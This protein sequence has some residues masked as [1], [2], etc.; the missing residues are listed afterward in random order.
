M[1]NLNKKRLLLTTLLSTAFAGT[2][3]VPAVAQTADD[4]QIVVTGSRIKKKDFT[5]NAPVATVEAAQFERTGSV[6]TENLINTLPQT[7]PGLDRTSNNPGNGSAT[8]NLRG[9]GSN[10]TLVL[11]NGTRQVP[12]GGGG[13]VDLNTIPTALIQN[14]EVLTGGASSVYGSDAVAGVVNFIYNDSFEGV[15]VDAGVQ[16]TEAGDAGLYNA[17]ITMGANLDGGRG[18]VALNINYTNR[19]DLFQGDRDFSNVALFDNGPG[20]LVA[21]G[22][23]GVPGTSIFSVFDFGRDVGANA[24]IDDD[25]TGIETL[26]FG[27]FDAS[28]TLQ[29]FR[30]NDEPNDFYNYAPVNY[31]Q[32]PQERFSTTALARYEINNFAEAYGRASFSSNKVDSQLAPTPIFQTATFSLD[33]N[34]FIDAATQQIIS[35]SIGQGVDTDMDGIDD[36]A[37]GFLRRRLVEVGPRQTKDDNQAFQILAGVRGDL[38]FAEGW[39][40]DVYLSEGR[41]LRSQQQNGNV[42][43][44]RFNAGLLLADADGDG[45]VDLDAN[46]NPTCAADPGGSTVACAPM[47]LFGPGNISEQSA[48][49]LNTAVAARATYEQTVFGANFT[50]DLGDF[51]VNG[52]A[53]GA[54]FGI[55]YIE[56]E[57]SFDPSQ[58]LAAATIAGFN[59][60]PAVSGIYDVWSAYG[61]ASIPLLS[62]KPFA[63]SVT[64]DVAGRISD[65]STSGNANTWKIGGD[66]AVNDELRFRGNYN[67]AVRAPSIAEL[68]TP[69]GQNFPGGQ[70]P[71][72]ANAP[73]AIT[74]EVRAICES[75]GV[76]AGS[77][78]S[79]GI[80][81]ISS[82]VPTLDA[83]NPDLGVETAETFTI[84]AV[85]R[86]SYVEG[87][88]VSVDYYD[89]TIEDA[90][91][92]VPIQSLLNLCFYNTAVG[93][94]GSEFCNAL[95]LQSDG[96]INVVNRQSENVGLITNRGVDI[97]AT[98]TLETADFLGSDYGSVSLNY[99][100]TINDTND[101]QPTTLVD[102]VITCAGEFGQECGTPDPEYRHR[103]T[104]IWNTDSFSTQLVWRLIGGTDDD[105]GPGVASIDELDTFH[106]FDGS[107]TW[108]ASD[109]LAFTFGINNLFDEQPPILGDNQQ[110]AN[111]YPNTY[112][113]F[114][115]TFFLNAKTRF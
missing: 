9:L 60:S 107:T 103:M 106:Y 36:T 71:C 53:I 6:N 20:E 61:E 52:D 113:V 1:T 18:N 22:S 94:V 26:G 112:D 58:D 7:V 93:G 14:V 5:S 57:F 19:E 76:P 38:W 34:P 111:T 62:D 88:T 110:Q 37:R 102:D 11:V 108:D 16:M 90:I 67:T 86:P 99:L 66:W 101:L 8:V 87:L 13:V 15:Q 104:G 4:D 84:G 98:Y 10:R 23:S 2:L 28:G 59:G 73:Q 45:N 82:Q 44:A 43:R 89:I 69:A 105:Q 56:N 30:L 109:N 55:E 35:D 31:I 64:L 91:V 21:G 81:T 85:Y 54:A 48:A 17:G 74:A 80:N 49:Y 46:G 29:P 65:Y 42:N 78:G 68:F 39:D 24:Y 47:N 70:F 33:G 75:L 41:T 51:T 92:T 3:A 95:T 100:G 114:G 115:R 25:P 96:S 63:Q 79:A 72:S 12:F 97:A 40:Y 50:G 32:L 83:G 77:V 27:V